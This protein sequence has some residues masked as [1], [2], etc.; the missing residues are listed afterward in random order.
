MAASETTTQLLSRARD[1]SRQARETGEEA[2]GAAVRAMRTLEKRV[3]RAVLGDF[4][5]GLSRIGGHG[6]YGVAVREVEK[7]HGIDTW[8]PQDGRRTLV[9]GKDGTLLIAWRWGDNIAEWYT[10][11]DGD[12]RVEDLPLMVRAVARALQRHTERAHRTQATHA[13]ALGLAEALEKALQAA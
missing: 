7:A 3:Q 6:F 1:A 13:R 4:L 8:L 11:Q 10:A 12:L 2:R 5:R 9:M